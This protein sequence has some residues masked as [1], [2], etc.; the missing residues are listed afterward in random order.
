MDVYGLITGTRPSDFARV[1]QTGFLL[2]MV[3]H[4][5]NMIVSVEMS[6]FSD[7]SKVTLLRTVNKYI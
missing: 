6:D 1:A 5:L 3:T 4:H 2:Q 7:Q